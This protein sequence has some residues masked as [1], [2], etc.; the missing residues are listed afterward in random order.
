MSKWNVSVCFHSVRQNRW[1]KRGLAIVPTKFGISFTAVFLNQVQ[2]QNSEEHTDGGVIVLL[3]IVSLCSRPELWSTSTLTA[4][5]WWPTGGRRWDRDSTPRWSRLP[6]GFWVSPVQRSTSQ[7]PAPT[8]S[9]TPAPLPPPPPRTST[10][11]LCRTPVRSSW[12]VWN[13][14]RPRT[15]KDHGKTGWA[16][17]EALSDNYLLRTFSDFIDFPFCFHLFQVRAAYFDRVNLSTSGF[18]K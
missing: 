16:L 17:M 9:P 5:C 3:V 4:P 18:Y 13:R 8:R 12:S 10:E 14:T 1:T 11:P 15:P 7:R 2:S 6:A